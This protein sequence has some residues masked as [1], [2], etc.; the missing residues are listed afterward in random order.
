VLTVATAMTAAARA[1][2]ESR[3]CHRRT[4]HPE[5][6]HDW[7]V[8]LDVRLDHDGAVLVSRGAAAGGSGGVA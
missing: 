5:P 8:H 1:R 7:L 4:D 3:G 6:S 2:E